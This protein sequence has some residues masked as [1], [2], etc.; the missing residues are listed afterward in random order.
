MKN[1]LILIMS[2]VVSRG[3]SGRGETIRKDNKY[4]FQ[5]ALLN[6]MH[7]ALLSVETFTC[8]I[9]SYQG[10]EYELYHLLMPCRIV[11]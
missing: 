3:V 6:R 4:T 5:N 10:V 1:W 8:H 7:Y 2:C 9:S 11:C